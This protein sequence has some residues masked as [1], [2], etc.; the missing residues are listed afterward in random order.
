MC[1]RDSSV[2]DVLYTDF[3][4]VLANLKFKSSSGVVVSD[5]DLKI[6]TNLSVFVL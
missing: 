4:E 5:S 3:I 1:I 2:V 6:K